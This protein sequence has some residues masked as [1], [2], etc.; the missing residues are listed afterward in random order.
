MSALLIAIA[1]FCVGFVI[2]FGPI[3]Y[4]VFIREKRPPMDES[5][6]INHLRLVWFAIRQP[7]EFVALYYV[8]SKQFYE[9][10]NG[11]MVS[12]YGYDLAF[13]WLTRDEGENVEGAI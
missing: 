12:R 7:E 10:D 11:E 2:G 13:P 4:F 1:C 5:N 8:A 9:D 3:L 6:R